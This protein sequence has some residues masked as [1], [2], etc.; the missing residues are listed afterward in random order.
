M[1]DGLVNLVILVSR[2]CVDAIIVYLACRAMIWLYKDIMHK[3]NDED[4]DF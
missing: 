3:I 4:D 2:L 1:S